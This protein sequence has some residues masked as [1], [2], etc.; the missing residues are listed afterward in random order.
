MSRRH[1]RARARRGG[2]TLGFTLIE[3]MITVAIIGILA[4]VAIPSYTQ[5]VVRSNRAA[6]EALMLEVS[7]AQERF[8]LDNR[9]YA[10]DMAT[11]G[12]TTIPPEVASKYTV[13]TAPVAGP[14]PGYNI[15]ATPLGSQLSAD[16]ACG[17]L[18]LTSAGAKS[19]SGSGSTCWK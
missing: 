1:A 2:P 18:T 13:T 14:P 10:A 6:A 7:G 19:A 15:V 8:L 12:Y 11:L 17:T 5:Y 9:A 4:S 16:T 3:L